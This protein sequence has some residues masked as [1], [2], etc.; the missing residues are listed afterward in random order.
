MFQ[1]FVTMELR[2]IDTDLLEYTQIMRAVVQ[3]IHH[4][5]NLEF[6]TL[7]GPQAECVNLPLERPRR[8]LA[9]SDLNTRYRNIVCNLR[10]TSR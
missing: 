3:E 7:L 2:I 1:R 4:P 10:T 5:Q 9:K 8:C 6:R